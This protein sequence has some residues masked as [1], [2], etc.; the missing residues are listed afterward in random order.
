MEASLYVKA[1]PVAVQNGTRHC[2]A[3]CVSRAGAENA[4]AILPSIVEQQTAMFIT[5]Q[6][7]TTDSRIVISM[8]FIRRVLLLAM[9]A[10]VGV[11]AYN[12]WFGNGW[13]L[14]PRTNAGAVKMETARTRSAELAATVAETGREAATRLE[15]NKR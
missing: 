7:G 4:S 10:G 3:W 5:A 11:F 15:V 2:C 9:I 8:R 6:H 14:G 1:R 12:H 13:T